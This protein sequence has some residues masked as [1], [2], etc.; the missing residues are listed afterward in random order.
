MRINCFY[1]LL[2][3]IDFL[4]QKYFTLF[5]IVSCLNLT[6]TLF[7]IQ[8]VYFL[9]NFQSHLL[10]NIDNR[11][12]FWKR[13][14]KGCSWI[15]HLRNLRQYRHLERVFNPKLVNKLL[16]VAWTEYFMHW[17]TVSAFEIWHVFYHSYSWY[18]QI[19]EHLNTFHHID[20]C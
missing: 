2:F 9:I 6:C 20:I 16:G 15:W 4:F 17:A 18:F 3:S 19:I 12:T 1:Y 13:Q 5:W 8:V 14:D 10:I 11:D 7:F